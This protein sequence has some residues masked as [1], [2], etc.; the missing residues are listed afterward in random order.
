MCIN[1]ECKRARIIWENSGIGL[2]NDGIGIDGLQSEFP[3]AATAYILEIIR[4]RGAA[5]YSSLIRRARASDERLISYLPLVLIPDYVFVGRIEPLCIGHAFLR[6]GF[7]FYRN[8]L[9]FFSF[10]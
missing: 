2:R 7:P 1:P 5:M 6:N 10:G 8:G 4:L 9:V 3:D